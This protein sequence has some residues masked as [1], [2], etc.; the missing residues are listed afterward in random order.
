M[1]G[2]LIPVRFGADDHWTLP[3]HQRGWLTRLIRALFRRH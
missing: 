3:A 2:H 1:L